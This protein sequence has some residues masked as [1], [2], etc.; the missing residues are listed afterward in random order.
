MITF[1][2]PYTECTA[3][4]CEAAGGPGVKGKFTFSPAS[5]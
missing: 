3:N 5:G 1:V 4:D 2:A